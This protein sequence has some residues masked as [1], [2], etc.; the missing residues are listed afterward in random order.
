MTSFFLLSRYDLYERITTFV[1]YALQHFI[2]IT[3][4]VWSMKWLILLHALYERHRFFRADMAAEPCKEERRLNRAGTDLVSFP[5]YC[6]C[7]ALINAALSQKGRFIGVSDVLGKDEI[8]Q[9]QRLE[10]FSPG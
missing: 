1:F 10:R 7:Q 5:F 6:F 2:S 3:A 4:P 8:V 9:E